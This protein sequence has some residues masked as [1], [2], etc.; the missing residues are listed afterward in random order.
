MAS[1]TILHVNAIGIM[2]ALE[3]GLDR[4]LRGRPFVVANA[5]SPRSVVLDLSPQAHREGLRR[6]M[7]LSLAHNLCSGV[8]VRSPRPEL[9][10]AAEERLWSIGLDYTPLVERA[11]RGHLFIDLAGTRRLFGAP[12]DAAQKLRGRILEETGLS[13]SIALASNKTVSKVAT[14]V[15]RPAGFVALSPNEEGALVRMQPVGLLPGV[16]PVLLGRFGLLGIDE[17]GDLADLSE[18]EAHAIGPRGPELVTRARGIDSSPVDPEPPERRFVSGEVVFEPDTTDP[19]LLRL[20]SSALVAELAFALRKEGLGARRALVE[21]TYTDGLH[22]SGRERAARVL[23]RD[24]ELLMMALS[25]LERARKRRVRVR[26]LELKLSEI[27]S[28]GPELDLF[29]PEDLRLSRLQAAL[30]K[31]HGRFGFA[32]IEPCSLLAARA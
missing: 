20:R 5:S 31:I 22:S 15:F 30:D 1:G 25:A 29:E 4:S 7:V 21:L 26:R 8:E 10:R 13:P 12:E 17:I 11:G 9:Y 14:R 18:G 19:E 16:G 32:S 6:G 2:A 23:A 27:E 3:E 28:A 24:D